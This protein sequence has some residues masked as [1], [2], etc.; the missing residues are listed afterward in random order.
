VDVEKELD[1]LYQLP[2]R[3]FVPA[4]NA[5]AK[6]LRDQ[7]RRDDAEHVARRERPTPTAWLV[8]QLHF[9]DRALLDAL[10]AS[11]AALR[12]AQESA[13]LQ[14]EIADAKRAHQLALSRATRRAL[15]IAKAE[16]VTSNA[17]LKRKTELT[18][19][20]LSASPDGVEPPPGRMALELE[21]TGFDAL[22]QAAAPAPRK[23]KR[24]IHKTDDAAR[25]NR[26]AGSR[27]LIESLDKELRKLERDAELVA[28]RADRAAREADDATRRATEMRATAE[29]VRVEAD[30][31]RTRVEDARRQL[32]DAR[33]ALEETH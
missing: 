3:E 17:T 8:N 12:S 10:L 18:L 31:A 20:L 22:S 5:A 4:R 25:E 27:T 21:P 16:A 29:A 7:G 26:L 14:A 23:P 2:L 11:G 9:R 30:G 15:E 1:R 6:A 33:R 32:E 28:I 19:T 13:G 24:D